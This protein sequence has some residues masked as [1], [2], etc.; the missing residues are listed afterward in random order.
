MSCL[1]AFSWKCHCLLFYCY[2]RGE[3]CLDKWI[4]HDIQI[5]LSLQKFT[6]LLLIFLYNAQQIQHTPPEY[7]IWKILLCKTQIRYNAIIRVVFCSH[8]RLPGTFD[9]LSVVQDTGVTPSPRADT[10]LVLAQ[11]PGDTARE[12]LQTSLSR[13]IRTSLGVRLG[14]VKY[15]FETCDTYI[16]FLIKC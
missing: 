5:V 14:R 11:E 4:W 9:S 15:H 16:E 3:M 13:R 2:H 8:G 6:Q 12:R 10:P 1:H 7:K